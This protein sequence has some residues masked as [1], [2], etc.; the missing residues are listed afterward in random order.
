VLGLDNIITYIPALNT[1]LNLGSLFESH[2]DIAQ[3]RIMYS[4]ALIR[5]KKVFGPDYLKSRSLRDELSALYTTVKNK[6]FVGVEKHIDNLQEGLS[7][8]GIKNPFKIKTA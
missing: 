4:K 3:A 2:A 5:Y 1:I 6:V 7:H 8:L